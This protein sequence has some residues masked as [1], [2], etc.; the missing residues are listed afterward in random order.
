MPGWVGNGRTVRATA[1]AMS[2][3]I[4]AI[5]Q[6]GVGQPSGAEIKDPTIYPWA[7]NR[8]PNPVGNEQAQDKAAGDTDKAKRAE[9]L[10]QLG[11]IHQK[12]H[13]YSQAE[14][15]YQAALALYTELG[16]LPEKARVL[17]HLGKVYAYNGQ[18]AKAMEAFNQALTIRD[19]LRD[20]EGR[21]RSLSDIGAVHYQQGYYGSALASYK[22]ALRLFQE[23][24]NE[25]HQT[26]SKLLNNIALA[27]TSLG[28]YQEAAGVYEQALAIRD[29]AED[30]T[31]LANTLNNLGYSY[32]KQ[33]LHQKAIN[34]YQRAL[35]VSPELEDRVRV[36]ILNNL[37]Y[38]YAELERHEEALATLQKALALAQATGDRRAEGRILDSIGTVYMGQQRHDAALDQFQRALLPKREVG[39]REGERATSANIGKALA[40]KGLVESAIIFYKQAINVSQ[41][42][43][44]DLV[45]LTRK[46]QEIYIE[47]LAQS[48]RELAG[49]LIDEGRLAEAIQV[50]TMLK[51]AEYFEYLRRCIDSDPRTTKSSF[52]ERDQPFLQ[53]QARQEHRLTL[54][55]RE[56]RELR[57]KWQQLGMLSS[58]E[59]D[60][61]HVLEHA[62]DLAIQDFFDR[63]LPALEEEYKQGEPG[64]P[65]FQAEELKASTGF[66]ATLGELVPGTVAI[67]FLPLADTLR[68]I[69][70]GNDPNLA[71]ISEK[72]PIGKQRLN[73]LIL[74]Y[75]D[76][77]RNPAGA[78]LPAAQELYGRLIA[79]IAQTLEDMQAETLLV[80]LDGALRYAPLAALH[81]GSSYL[82][83]KYAVA[84]YTPAAK[85]KLKDT[86]V[87]RWRV[88]GMGVSTSEKPLPAV[89]EELDGI[90]KEGADDPRGVLPGSTFLN[91]QF[92]RDQ[93]SQVLQTGQSGGYTVLH[94]ASHFH[95]F[96]GAG[97][98]SFLL[99][100]KGD[101]L[102][103][104]ELRPPRYPL[105]KVD[106]LT[107]SACDTGLYDL[108]RA[109]GREIEGFATRAQYSGAKAVLA[110]LWEVSDRSTGEFMQL[111]YKL[112][113]EENLTKAE[114]LR[115][116]QETFIQGRTS[117]DGSTAKRDRG[118]RPVQESS[119]TSM[120]TP[121]GHYSHPYYWA[122]FILMGNFL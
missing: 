83:E 25:D 38:A 104:A 105:T 39:D 10:R 100:G 59:L 87:V 99:L 46:E 81:D 84:R 102:R 121:G 74:E 52:R 4:F 115:R 116:A 11:E 75:Y 7:A 65:F 41:D 111:M 9:R 56:H 16:L 110:T 73:K 43:R 24:G 57:N 44:Q 95:F 1:C 47:T 2:L 26:Q 35:D 113:E 77:L 85:D 93:L 34:A 107:L 80:Y 13:E 89:E 18:F 119:D 15:A 49:L 112:R 22:Q 62:L 32:A 14:K 120:S 45:G 8:P 30:Q 96:P 66:Q 23:A 31:G 106:L 108:D 55:W 94:L 61:L 68:V 36:S 70:V 27:Y 29:A 98:E 109:D 91:E 51:E 19:D 122:P 12:A 5:L 37:G 86:D 17:Q 58:E 114:A 72:L 21:A 33:H 103:P 88:A 20:L 40:K 117:Q 53:R 79:P 42:M 78:P 3:A 90:V 92:T 101:T 67:Y 97:E 82:A 54:T 69:V 60:R 71:P 63:V 50:L 48:Y 118:A 64:S 76:A 28:Q 6:L